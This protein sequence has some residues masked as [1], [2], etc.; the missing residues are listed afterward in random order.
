MEDEDQYYESSEI[1]EE[2]SEGTDEAPEEVIQEVVLD[3][4][5][6]ENSVYLGVIQALQDDR[7]AQVLETSDLEIEES[8]PWVV[9][10]TSNVLIVIVLFAIL[11]AVVIRTLLR[12]FEW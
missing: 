8:D 2:D 1:I 4:G 3:Y 6:I 5:A 10:N 7:E 12:S 11:G 9:V